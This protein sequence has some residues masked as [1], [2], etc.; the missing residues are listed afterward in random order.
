MNFEFLITFLQDW[1]MKT[2]QKVCMIC[3]WARQCN[4]GLTVTWSCRES[5]RLLFCVGNRTQQLGVEGGGGGKRV[6]VLCASCFA[7]R[8][9]NFLS[10]HA[11][12]NNS[13]RQTQVC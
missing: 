1:K 13:K 10:R 6:R 4:D 7:L 12:V 3:T 11:P 8:W 2:S 9:L 5:S